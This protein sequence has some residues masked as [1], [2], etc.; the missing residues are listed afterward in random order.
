MEPEQ[1]IPAVS[2]IEV[3]RAQQQLLLEP[4][5]ETAVQAEAAHQQ[6]SSKPQ[7]G[8]RTA[9]GD[10]DGADEHY[11]KRPRAEQTPDADVSEGKQND[12]TG[13]GDSVSDEAGSDNDEQGTRHLSEACYDPLTLA[14]LFLAQTSCCTA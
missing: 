8:K 10:A 4:P 1:C 3:P 7:E 12:S 5:T 11:A 6:T 13:A 2:V 9:D 14:A